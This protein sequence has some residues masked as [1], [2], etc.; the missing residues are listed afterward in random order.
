MSGDSVAIAD[1]NSFIEPILTKSRAIRAE[2]LSDDCDT[3]E[4]LNNI[5]TDL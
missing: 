4:K 2:I 5:E 3:L 1:M